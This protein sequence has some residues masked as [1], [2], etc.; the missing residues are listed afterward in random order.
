MYTFQYNI[1][2]HSLCSCYVKTKVSLI[3]DCISP[4]LI[5]PIGIQSRS[6]HIDF[7]SLF[8]VS[9]S[10]GLWSRVNELLCCFCSFENIHSGS[11]D[12]IALGPQ[13][14]EEW[15]IS[16]HISKLGWHSHQEF[17]ALQGA[18]EGG[19]HLWLTAAKLQLLPKVSPRQLRKWKN[20]RCKKMQGKMPQESWGSGRE[21]FHWAQALA[22]SH[23]KGKC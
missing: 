16:C 12:Y 21:C 23:T 15:S 17:P 4:L 9:Q 3:L 20:A 8:S 2:K 11:W 1:Y 10:R 22:S 5:L 13:D 7:C 19:I 14:H 18:Q 6:G